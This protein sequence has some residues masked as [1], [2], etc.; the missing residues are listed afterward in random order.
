MYNCVCLER[1][2]EREKGRHGMEG[3]VGIDEHA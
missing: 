1:E 3:K 2:R